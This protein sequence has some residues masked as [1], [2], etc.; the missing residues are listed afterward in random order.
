MSEY[1][2]LEQAWLAEGFSVLPMHGPYV[3][4]SVRL[5]ARPE[6]H[7]LHFRVAVL[8]EHCNGYATAHGGFLATLADIWL[9]YNIYHRLPKGARMVT[10]NLTVD[11]LAPAVPGGWLESQIDRVRL[12]SRLCHASGA[13]LAAGR[14]VVAM[15]G[16]FAMIEGRPAG[17]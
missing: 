16:T 10:A 13:I 11:Y 12:G 3:S 2:Q 8:P 6:D 9:A 1:S 15:R 5:F 4:G 17:D 14:P 7:H